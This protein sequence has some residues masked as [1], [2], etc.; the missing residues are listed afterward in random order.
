MDQ[1]H[2]NLETLISTLSSSHPPHL[3]FMQGRLS[4]PVDGR[5]QAFPRDH[6]R[7]EFAI[8]ESIG[9]GLMEWTID[10]D[11][12]E[13]NPLMTRD[14]RE[15]IRLLTT[16]HGVRILSLTGD[17]FMQAP[18][19]KASNSERKVLEV[20]FLSVVESCSDLGVGIA[21]VPLVDNGSIVNALEAEVFL[22][23]MTDHTDRFRDLGVTIAFESD[24]APDQFSALIA[25]LPTTGFGINYD[26]GNSAAL[27]YDPA[28][29]IAAYGERIVNVH[30]K[31]RLLGGSTVPLGTG[32]AQL[33]RAVSL[34]LDQGYGG[35]FILQTARADDHD[36]SGALSRYR[37]MTLMWMEHHEA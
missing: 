11:G 22:Q 28:V 12:L 2:I 7:E 19:W 3:G 17:C 30:I 25:A 5:I 21:V 26:I 20:A 6:W 32:V 10:Q 27:G 34:L 14:G 33:E 31:D 24:Y 9:F 29:E 15:E 13:E 4:P 16:Q 18:F 1:P 36:H 8:A 37:D 23:F 35:N